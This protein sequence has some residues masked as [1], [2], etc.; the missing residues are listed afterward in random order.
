MFTSSGNFTLHVHAGLTTAS[1]PFTM[2]AQFGSQ[3]GHSGAFLSGAPLRALTS[4][5]ESDKFVAE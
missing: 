1:N 3:R 4:L 2:I 5:R